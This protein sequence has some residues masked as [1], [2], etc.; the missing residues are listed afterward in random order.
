MTENHR[1]FADTKAGS[2]RRRLWHSVPAIGVFC[3][4]T[5]R[6]AAIGIAKRAGNMTRFENAF[7]GTEKSAAATDGAL[8]VAQARCRR[9]AV[10][11]FVIRRRI[12][13]LLGFCNPADRQGGGIKNPYATARLQSLRQRFVSGGLAGAASPAAI[14]SGLRRN[15]DR[16]SNHPIGN[17]ANRAPPLELILEIGYN[18]RLPFRLRHAPP[19]FAALPPGRPIHREDQGD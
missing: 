6:H 16:K 5:R 3:A 8:R 14:D 17:A 7:A 2:I 9:M 13:L 12:R 18:L 11:E 1:A 15:D 10:T 19:C 4:P